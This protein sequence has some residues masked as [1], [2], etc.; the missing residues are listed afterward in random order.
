VSSA[1]GPTLSVSPL[2]WNCD[3][4]TE[5]RWRFQTQNVRKS[6]LCNTVCHEP[7]PSY[8]RVSFGTA[9]WSDI[10]G[11]SYLIH[12]QLFLFKMGPFSCPECYSATLLA[13]YGT[14]SFVKSLFSPH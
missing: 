8:G 6:R 12:S 2:A 10:K 3:H 4:D 13:L 7:F 11:H 1:R 9:P 14:A 5:R